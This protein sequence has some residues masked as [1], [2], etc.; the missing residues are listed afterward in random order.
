[1]ERGM[2][3]LEDIDF[4]LLDDD[5]MYPTEKALDLIENYSVGASPNYVHEALVEW[6]RI[7]QSMWWHADWGWI[8]EKGH[9]DIFDQPIKRYHISTGGWSGNESIIGAMME[10]RLFWAMTWEQSR[11]GGHYI[12]SFRVKE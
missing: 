7:I 1:M 12:F 5:G 6:F 10:N 2:I 9:D 4:E 3:K 11:R 8:E